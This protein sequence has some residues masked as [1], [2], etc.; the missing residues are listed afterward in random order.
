MMVAPDVDLGGAH[1]EGEAADY[2]L[3]RTAALLND[4]LGLYLSEEQQRGFATG[5]LI[6]TA[7][8]AAVLAWNV[9]S[10]VRSRV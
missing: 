9:S 6:G 8:G 3:K 4:R 10:M 5:L 7:L 2:P 1:P